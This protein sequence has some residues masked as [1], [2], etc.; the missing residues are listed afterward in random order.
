MK[1]VAALYGRLFVE[2]NQNWLDSSKKPG[3]AALPDGA[4]EALRQGLYGADSPIAVAPGAISDI[5]WFFDE[6]TPVER[7]KLQAEIDRW[8]LTPG[9][10]DHTGLLV[11]R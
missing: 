5:E 1:D 8:N 6:A 3:T 11:H 7:Q 9:G 2:V 4:R 10:P